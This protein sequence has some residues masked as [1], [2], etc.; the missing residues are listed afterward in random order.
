MPSRIETTTTNRGTLHGGIGDN[1]PLWETLISRQGSN[2]TPRDNF[3]LL[4]W[5]PSPPD[6]D[7]QS[8]AG[9]HFVLFPG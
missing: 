8:P 4:G 2:N 1:S 7:V 3:C 9:S 5:H 6:R